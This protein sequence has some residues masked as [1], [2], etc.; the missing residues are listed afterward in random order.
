[1]AEDLFKKEALKGN[2]DSQIKKVEKPKQEAIKPKEITIKLN[3]K[4]LI[5]SGYIILVLALITVIVLQHYEVIP[6]RSDLANIEK[7]SEVVGSIEEETVV[8]EAPIEVEAVVEEEPEEEVVEEEEETE[9]LLPITGE[10]SIIIDKINLDPK[11]NIE[12]YAKVTSVK[13]T[14][15][16][17]DEDFDPT[18]KAYLKSYTDDEKEIEL[19]ELEAGEQTTQTSTKLFFG[20]NNV[21]QQKTLVLNLYNE[22]NKMIATAEKSFT[23]SD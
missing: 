12:D 14:I 4:H 9:D 6:T 23:S 17:Q 10:V 13:F 15:L 1:M 11:P 19:E 3:T 16:N 20:F 18:V 8:E 22:K 5:Y 21:D 7:E 2:S